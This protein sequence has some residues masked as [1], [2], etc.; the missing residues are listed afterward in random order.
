MLQ[1]HSLAICTSNRTQIQLLLMLHF[2][3]EEDHEVK[4]WDRGQEILP[5]A[6]LAVEEIN[7]NATILPDYSLQLSV[8]SIGR[9]VE[10][11]FASNY[12]ALVPFAG[13]TSDSTSLHLGMIGGPF[14][15]PLL[16]RLVSPLAS[17]EQ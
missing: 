1:N 11:K 16:D 14:C 6:Q 12:Q 2:P 10:D 5:A 17:H 4:I 9:C 8:T 7:T 13:I 15:P 3:T